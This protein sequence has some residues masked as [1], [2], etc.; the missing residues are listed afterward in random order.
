MLV[1]AKVLELCNWGLQFVV[2]H[3]VIDYKGHEML[4]LQA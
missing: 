3:N 2:F 1:L 4:R